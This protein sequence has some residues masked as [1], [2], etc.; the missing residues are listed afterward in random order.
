[1]ENKLEMGQF[2]TYLQLCVGHLMIRFP[3][4][5]TNLEWMARLVLVY[6]NR[7]GKKEFIKEFIIMINTIQQQHGD[8]VYHCTC[9]VSIYIEFAVDAMSL[10][11]SGSWV[12]WLMWAARD[13]STTNL[14]LYCQSEI[15]TL[16]ILIYFLIKENRFVYI[17]Q[18]ENRNNFYCEIYTDKFKRFTE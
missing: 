14:L 7:Q 17:N 18:F 6:H 3:R 8:T 9:F 15:G 10:S 11:T 1:M 2:V 16:N 13:N 12:I 5:R 4:R